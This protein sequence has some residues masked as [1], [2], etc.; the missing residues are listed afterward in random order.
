[1]ETI[2]NKDMQIEEMLETEDLVI[3]E[4]NESIKASLQMDVDR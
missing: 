3:E 4:V 2:D 1:M